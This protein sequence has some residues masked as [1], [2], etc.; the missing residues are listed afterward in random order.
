[1]IDVLERLNLDRQAGEDLPVFQG[2][3]AQA[4]LVTDHNHLQGSLGSMQAPRQNEA[5][6][7][8]VADAA[9]DDKTFAGQTGLAAKHRAG[10]LAGV[11]H[12]QILGNA[13]ALNGLAVQR[14]HLCNTADFHKRLK[15]FDSW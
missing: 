4:I 10:G 13:E 6:A 2:C 14:P 5:V 3:P 1:M 12:E 8:V 9:D 7:A 15:S 11:L